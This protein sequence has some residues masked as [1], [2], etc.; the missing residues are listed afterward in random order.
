MSYLCIVKRKQLSPP[1]TRLIGLFMLIR[2]ND[3]FGHDYYSH[4]GCPLNMF[5]NE[6]LCRLASL[7][8]RYGYVIKVSTSNNRRGTLVGLSGLYYAT[9]G[10]WRLLAHV[11]DKLS[12][13]R[14]DV[15]RYKSKRPDGLCI[16]FYF[17]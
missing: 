6:V 13:C 17:K 5:A 2:V 7:I 12:V 11:A 14:K 1:E 15:F 4:D 8:R 3:L 10:D 9:D 16:S